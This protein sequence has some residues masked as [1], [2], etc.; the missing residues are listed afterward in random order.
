VFI[1][2]VAYF[3]ALLQPYA[4]EKTSKVAECHEVINSNVSR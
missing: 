3:N 1:N 4:T 2:G